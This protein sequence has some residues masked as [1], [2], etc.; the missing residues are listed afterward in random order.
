MITCALWVFILLSCISDPEPRQTLF[1]FLTEKNQ[2]LNLWQTND[3]QKKGVGVRLFVEKFT[4]HF[5]HKG[6]NAN[7]RLLQL[8]NTT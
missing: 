8:L 2:C 7:Y 5:S 1:S 3:S 6:N 4:V